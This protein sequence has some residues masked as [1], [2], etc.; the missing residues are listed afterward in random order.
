MSENDSTFL[1][2][3]VY[4]HA[5]T[6]HPEAE[7]KAE[8]AGNGRIQLYIG[9]WLLSVSVPSAEVIA[10]A[11]DAAIDKARGVTFGPVRMFGMTSKAAD[12][13]LVTE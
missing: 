8:V 1:G 4:V 3:A 2:D 13:K 6:A 5:Q 11:L 10:D 7:V 12:L 9:P